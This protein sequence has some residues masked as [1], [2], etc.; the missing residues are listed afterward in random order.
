[1]HSQPKQKIR[2]RVKVAKYAGIYRSVSCNYEIAFRDSDGKLRFRTIGPN[3]QDA[4]A[5]R[6][7][8][9]GKVTRGEVVRPSKVTF[10]DFA[11]EWLAGLDKRPR[12]IAAYRYALDRHL[13]P[14]FGSRKLSDVTTD[15]V[16]GLVRAMARNGYAPWTTSGSLSTLSGMMRRAERKGVIARNPVPGLE[17]GERPKVGGGEKRVLDEGEIAR[18]LAAAGPSRTLLAFFLFSGVR[19]GEALGLT[20]A[21][22]DFEGRFIRVRAQLN[23]E[24]G[25]APMPKTDAGRRDVVL[26]PQLEKLLKAHRLASVFS[27]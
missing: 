4:V 15:D 3:L 19:L 23:R 24:R 16:A 13:L 8:V 18:L 17:R 26:V 22:L 25:L 5:A 6:A 7:E 10:A 11:E 12:T 9:V 20:W 2:R 1:M 21:N 14:R 27:G